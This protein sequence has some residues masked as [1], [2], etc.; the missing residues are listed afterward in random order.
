MVVGVFLAVTVAVVE[1]HRRRRERRSLL[2]LLLGVWREWPCSASASGFCKLLESSAAGNQHWSCPKLVLCSLLKRVLIHIP[3][4][5]E[6]VAKLFQK[7][8]E[9]MKSKALLRP[10]KLLYPVQILHILFGL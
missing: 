3:C 7:I 8:Q 2:A 1:A 10:E 5:M 4:F 6:S 9:M